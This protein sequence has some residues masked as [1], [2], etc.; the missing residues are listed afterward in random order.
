[1]SWQAR[2]RNCLALIET[3]QS[4]QFKTHIGSDGLLQVQ[5]PPEVKDIE[6]EVLVVFQPA[7]SVPTQAVSRANWRSRLAQARAQHGEQ[8]F[9]DSVELL[10]ED[11]N[12]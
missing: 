4:L 12:R 1:M 8:V 5:M 6:L 10:R 9:S 3:M 7:P 2:E 11:R